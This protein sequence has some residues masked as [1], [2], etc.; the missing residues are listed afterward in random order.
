MI[1]STVRA[2]RGSVRAVVGP[3]AVLGEMWTCTLDTAR[4]SVAVGRRV[5]EMLTPV[6]LAHLRL[7][8][9]LFSHG[10]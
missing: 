7:R 6:T 5:S 4:V 3:G 2:F 8:P 10:D 1:A 9:R